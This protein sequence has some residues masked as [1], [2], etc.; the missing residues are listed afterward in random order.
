[1]LYTPVIAQQCSWV[2]AHTRGEREAA[3]SGPAAH[4]HIEPTTDKRRASERP[5]LL[6]LLRIW[7][8]GSDIRQRR[9]PFTGYQ[10]AHP[11]GRDDN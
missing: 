3:M 1:M 6:T 8:D 11:R 5:P 10:P 7:F 9:V 4:S 2:L